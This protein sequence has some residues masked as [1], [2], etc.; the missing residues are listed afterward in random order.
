MYKYVS[1]YHSPQID[2]LDDSFSCESQV[3]SLD[4]RTRTPCVIGLITV[5]PISCR[6]SA[7]PKSL[8]R[9]VQNAVSFSKTSKQCRNAAS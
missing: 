6:K 7:V 4:L 3:V 9:Q 8:P 5:L 1:N 2:I